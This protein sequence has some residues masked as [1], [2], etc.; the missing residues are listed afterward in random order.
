MPVMDYNTMSVSKLAQKAL[1]QA[2]GG[3][4]EIAQVLATL[5]QTKATEELR[6]ELAASIDA[7]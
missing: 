5:A 1:D 2:F 3:N 6:K 7:K 4:T